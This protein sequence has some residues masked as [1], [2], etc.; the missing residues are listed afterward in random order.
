MNN[1]MENQNNKKLKTTS[2]DYNYIYI[3]SKG[4]GYFSFK[5]NMRI[6][7]GVTYIKCFNKLKRA[8]LDYNSTVLSNNLEES[9]KLIPLKDDKIL[10]QEEVKFIQKYMSKKSIQNLQSIHSSNIV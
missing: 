4:K 3:D 6:Q 8:I 7:T 10:E 9:Y 2:T 1:K 5:I